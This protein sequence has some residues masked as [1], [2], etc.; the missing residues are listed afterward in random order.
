MLSQHERRQLD[1]I[2]QGLRQDHPRWR[3]LQD[4][5]GAGWQHPVVLRGLLGFAVL[6]MLTG[7]LTGTVELFVQGL[8]IAGVPGGL[9]L[10]KRAR[11]ALSSPR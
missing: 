4:R 6:L 2:E 1:L 7:V 9:W 11:A 10:W 3:G 8:L 5:A